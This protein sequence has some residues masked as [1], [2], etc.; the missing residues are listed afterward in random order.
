MGIG[1]DD[2]LTEDNINHYT[3]LINGYKERILKGRKLNGEPED[4][5]F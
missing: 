4:F 1:F 5:N 2:D 3:S